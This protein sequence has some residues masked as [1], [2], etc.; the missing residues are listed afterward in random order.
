MSDV[1]AKPTAHRRRRL[2]W[3]I[4]GGLI[5]AGLAGLAAW[6]VLSPGALS[7]Y[8][9]PSEV[10]A[11]R[12]GWKDAL[13][14]GGRVAPGSLRREGVTV[15]FDLT[16]GHQRVPVSY[17]GDVPDTLKEGT[18]A[19]AEG[20]LQPDGSLRAERVLAKCSSKFV[21]EGSEPPEHLRK[22]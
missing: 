4:G 8:K 5:V 10:V 15:S 22:T 17:R 11:Q 9:T 21:P 7:Y 14:V 18:D 19:V 13:R 1:Q 20:S 2:R 16:D 3:V 12:E 6:S